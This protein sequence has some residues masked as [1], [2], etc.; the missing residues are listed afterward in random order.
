MLKVL[1]KA[2]KFTKACNIFY[3]LGKICGETGRFDTELVRRLA[4]P[5]KFS[6]PKVLIYKV[7]LKTKPSRSYWDKMLRENG[8]FEKRF[9]RPYFLEPEAR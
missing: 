8:A 5:E 9:D 1:G 7:L 4:K 6:K 2:G 3:Q